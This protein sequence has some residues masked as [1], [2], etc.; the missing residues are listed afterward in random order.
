MFPGGED[1]LSLSVGC[2]WCEIP[3]E[4]EPARVT[5]VLCLLQLRVTGH[6]GNA[7]VSRQLVRVLACE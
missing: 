4:P 5:K 2:G 7:Q 3:T 1:E 6:A